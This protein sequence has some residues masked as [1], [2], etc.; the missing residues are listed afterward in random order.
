MPLLEKFLA[1]GVGPN[2]IWCISLGMLGGP[3][4]RPD[5]IQILVSSLARFLYWYV[6]D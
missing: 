1:V 5:F 6:R 3:V 4:K 2:L